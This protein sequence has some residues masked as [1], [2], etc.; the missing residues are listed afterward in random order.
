MAGFIQ[1]PLQFVNL[2]ADNLRDRY[3]LV[4]EELGGPPSGFSVFKELIQNTDDAKASDLRFGRSPGLPRA[5]HPLLRA[6][7]LFFINN[8]QFSASD[9]RGIRS[10]GQ[11]SKAADQ[12]SIGKFGLGMKSVFHFCEAFF[13]LAHDGETAY[14][15]VLNPWSGE[16]SKESLHR[17]WDAFTGDDARLIR[18]HLASVVSGLSDAERL[19][20]LWIPLRREA[21]LGGTGAIV[22]QYPGDDDSL[23]TF[24]S[25]P[26]F[27]PRV[28]SLL[29]M[30]RH[31]RQVTY[32]DL[33]VEG[34]GDGPVFEVTLSDGAARPALFDAP[35]TPGALTAESAQSGSLSGRI[36]TRVGEARSEMGFSG[37]EAHLWNEE[38]R[39]LHSHERWPSSYVRNRD[40]HASEAKDKAQPHGAVIFSRAPGRGRLITHWTV[41]LPLDEIAAVQTVRCEGDDDFRLT[42]HGYFF[43]D[44]GRQGAIGLGECAGW[45]PDPNESEVALR[46]AWNC[47][48]LRANVFPLVIPALEDFCT[49]Q[50]LSDDAKGRL[51]AGLLK[52]HLVKDFRAPMTEQCIWLRELNP[53]GARWIRRSTA[54]KV[55]TLP[56]PVGDEPGRPWRLFPALEALCEDHWLGEADAPSLLH[57]SVDVQWSEAQL[58]KLIGS[59]KPRELFQ[60]VK[61]LDYLNAFLNGPA[62]PYLGTLAVRSAL[63]NLVRQGL[64]QLGEGRVGQHETRVA[65]IVGRL[66]P[67]LCF[68]IDNGL[69]ASLLQGLLSA[70]TDVLPLPARF[71]PQPTPENQAPPRG[72]AALSVSDAARLLGKVEGALQSELDA[73]EALQEAALKLSPLLIKGV[74]HDRRP[75]LL[76]RCEDL[77]ILGAHDCREGRRVPVSV[78]EIRAA[79]QAGTLFG[80]GELRSPLGLAPALQ[81]VLPEDRVLVINK[82]T[83]SLALEVDGALGACDGAAVLRC[84][85][86]QSRALG[87]RE[88]RA[89][90]IEKC[91][92]PNGPAEVRGLRFLLHADPDHFEDSDRLW[93]LG[94][95]QEPVWQKLWMQLV[96]G[97]ERPWNLVAA[98]LTRSLAG[99]ALEAA[100]IHDIGPQTVIDAIERQGVSRLDPAAFDQDECAQIL[101]A[102]RND[103]LWLAV[104]FH[105]TRQDKAVCGDAEHAYLE[106]AQVALDP[107]L[108]DGVHLLVVSVDEALASRQQRLLK[109]LD[110]KAAIEIALAHLHVPGV[111]RVILD[112]LEK[113]AARGDHPCED[114]VARLRALAWLPDAQGQRLRPSDVIDLDAA[115]EEL[116]RILAQSPGLFATP[117]DLAQ[118]VL[119]HGFYPQLRQDLFA[120]GR[121]GLAQLGRA[122][123]DLPA[124]QIGPV[125]LRDAAELEQA[126][127]VLGGYSHAGWQLIAALVRR[128][129]AE[130]CHATLLA[131]LNGALE[132]EALLGLLGWLARQGG[133]PRAIG[134]VFDRYLAVF[135]ALPEASQ[136]LGALMLRNQEG[137]WAPS[138]VLVSGVT[139]IAPAHVLDL[140]QARILEHCIVSE[141]RGPDAPAAAVATGHASDT[142]AA[143]QIL[144]DYFEP[145]TVR[146]APPL[147]GLLVALFGEDA[148]VK[149]LCE[150]LLGAARSREGLIDVVPWTVPQTDP[151]EL[152]RAW[153]EGYSLAQ[154]LDYFRFGVRIHVG[155]Q[156]VVRSILGEPVSVGLDLQVKTVFLDRPSYAQ[157]ANGDG[158]RVDLVLR[159]FAIE[160]YSDAQLSEILRVS[161]I[162][163]L[164]QVY[165]QRQAN[166]DALWNDLNQSDQV[167]IELAKALILDH[168]PVH[169]KYLGA[170]KHPAL[171]DVVQRYRVAEAREKE[172][173]GKPQE[174]RYRQEK[175]EALEQLQVR[176]ETGE[177]ARRAIL[178]A[179]KRKVADFQYQPDSVPFELFQNADDALRDLEHIDAFPAQPGDPG[180]DPL[181]DGIRRFVVESDGDALVFMHWGRAINQF[182]SK[183]FPGRERGFDRD[184]ENMLILSAS[185]KDEDVTGKFGLG[186]K[187]VWLVTDRPTILSGRL[188]AS[189]IGG[190]LPLPNR[191]EPSQELSAR[192]SARQPDR[193]WPG[194]A[195]HLPLRDLP[196]AEVLER[197]TAVAGTMVAFARSLRTIVVQDAGGVGV[198]ATWTP[199]PLAGCEGIELGR[200][201]QG[202]GDPLLVMKISLGEGALLLPVGRGGFVELPKSIPHVWVTA[203]LSQDDRLGFAINAMFEV[204]AGRSQLSKSGGKNKAI[205]C[206]LGAQL[207]QRLEALRGAVD[208]EWD[209]VREAM[210]LPAGLTAYDFWS[211]L[212]R[213]LL[214]RV[215]QLERQGGSRI[216]AEGL[217]A[218][219][220]GEL[221]RQHP[222]VPNGLP[223]GLCALIRWTEAKTVL[224]GALGETEVLRAVASARCFRGHLDPR[225]SVSA[226]LATWLRLLVADAL[227]ERRELLISV[228]LHDLFARL[229]AAKP[230]APEDANALGVALH[231]E[232]AQ[233]WHKRD[234]DVAKETFRDLERTLEKA[235]ERWFLSAAGSA[236]RAK[237]LLARGGS[238]EEARRWA[239]APDAQ[240]LAEEYG[241]HGMGFFRLCRGKLDAPA[242][243]L[244]AWLVEASD[245]PRRQAGL[246]YLLEGELAQQ[247]IEKLHADGL[248]SH[249]L[250][251]LK[252]QKD[253][254]PL[255]ADWTATDRARLLYH[256]LTTPEESRVIHTTV[257]IQPPLPPKP[258]NP[259]HALADIH[260]WWVDHRDEH[261]HAYRNRVYPEGTLPNLQESDSEA[262]DRSSWLLLL[263]LGGFHTMG[264]VGPEQHRGFIELCKRR[265]W[266]DVF[267]DHQPTER[268]EDWMR[269]LDQ[270]LDAQVDEQMYE[271]W[272]MRFPIIYKL[273]RQLTE[274][275]ELLLGLGRKGAPFDLELALMPAADAD[276]QGGGVSA[277]ALPKTLGKGAN[278][279][280]RELIRLGIIDGAALRQHAFVPYRQVQRL[281]AALGCDALQHASRP[282]DQSPLIS[283]F[284]HQ[285]LPDAEKATF[286]R[287]FDIP[288]QIVSD[289]W[290][291]QRDLLGRPL[292]WADAPW[293]Q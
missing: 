70:R 141:A 199:E 111:W 179:V 87:S 137:S 163:L 221:S 31:L 167:D 280:V 106:R 98:S 200:I 71:F 48:L 33:T 74:R 239:F 148:S 210:A 47:A 7:A 133:D 5:A 94:R 192:L 248:Q 149:A 186:F 152:R 285:H 39:A 178:D 23:L 267:I 180:V 136:S 204:D 10:F 265:G 291:L 189:I 276:Q 56:A 105:W 90:L 62:G 128:L 30:L 138:G 9:A 89:A 249:W 183:G 226:D 18:E 78:K 99:T 246:R 266:W 190:I 198:S 209:R 254:H 247:V 126:A 76:Q 57:P 144:R 22:G 129:G 123:A 60:D 195:I 223:E 134:Q 113:L 181:P 174:R 250:N 24:L 55:L 283:A 170:H 224:K 160:D 21:D 68:K 230:I 110:E 34:G 169:L 83:A 88:Q 59:V 252:E 274:Y 4:P 32:W 142:T 242:D 150:E 165:G 203:P 114:A 14:A 97:E 93:V 264:R 61:L 212:W 103:D 20:V 225:Q 19:F 108:L 244:K 257:T 278:F 237:R 26:T 135:A 201:L 231:P 100:D 216:V 158:Y 207:A 27:P 157:F 49:G 101:K 261:L 35:S 12:A 66:D 67:D 258:I 115:E 289:D 236:V 42:L 145:W 293:L 41:F 277:S 13:F 173:A 240:R 75:E 28:A 290:Q 52:T 177:A 219:A 253:D 125:A 243:M 235:G 11:N 255:I 139:G 79:E 188:R 227:S 222:I 187:S 112:A 84:L 220:L 65:R 260:D 77:R 268:F 217:L 29:P 118:D 213:V 161:A 156:L 146:V 45:T 205:A 218:T 96:G 193:H 36:H 63:G 104:P 228:S 256:I 143:A 175:A 50:R 245:E 15:E 132:T 102:V 211:S 284:V 16:A 54:R 162:F 6:P 43:I 159:R 154:A 269:V 51:S 17:D 86:Q 91:G 122:L 107:E 82:E 131:S 184:L 263:L 171:Q 72:D 271:Q 166:L 282:F 176:I 202:S 273:S 191:G 232:T 281:L 3:P 58:L 124:Y 95:N 251:E 8:G 206:R 155:E 127:G 73:N 259:V 2:I 151:R 238:D 69:P 109:P 197:F 46:K 116:E 140:D 168:V 119:V 81:Q 215:P 80:S 185:D 130:A 40:G 85:G 53:G 164:R 120:R 233:Q 182:G 279:I 147:V 194:T 37:R 234:E 117:G 270:Y 241:E 288:F 272:M 44:A 64:A 214:A 275:A 262:I 92:T 25:M 292:E 208:G 287:D 172:F 38:L 1:D 286:C 196:A 153:L 229:D 121:E